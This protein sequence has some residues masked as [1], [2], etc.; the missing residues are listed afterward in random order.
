M[1][2]ES[3][4]DRYSRQIILPEV[5]GRGQKRLLESKVFVIG[6]GE[7]AAYDYLVRA[8]IG[9]VESPHGADDNRSVDAALFLPS[10]S[11][12]S[13]QQTLAAGVVVHTWVADGNATI[14]QRSD[15]ANLQHQIIGRWFPRL[16]SRC[17]VGL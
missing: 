8:G 3:Q 4:I 1:L 17:S 11:Q 14:V 2:T 9:F 13:R 7:S 10:A 6:D 15:P 12:H 5:G 16:R